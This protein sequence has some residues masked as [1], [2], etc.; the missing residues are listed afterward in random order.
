MF[1]IV[2]AEE[3]HHL[4]ET[5]VKTYFILQNDFSQFSVNLILL[6]KHFQTP[7]FIKREGFH[8]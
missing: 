8:L 2:G 6:K 7:G 4:S 3:L 1:V 5:E